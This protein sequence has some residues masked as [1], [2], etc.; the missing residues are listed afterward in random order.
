MRVVF[1]DYGIGISE[2]DGRYFLNFDEETRG[3]VHCLLKPIL[4]TMLMVLWDGAS[5]KI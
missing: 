2:E 5:K 1:S 4:D 3:Q